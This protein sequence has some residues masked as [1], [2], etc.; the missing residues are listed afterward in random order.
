MIGRTAGYQIGGRIGGERQ[1]G[2]QRTRQD[3][4][5]FTR[6][7]QTAGS[8]D[9]LVAR[10]GGGGD[11]GRF[12]DHQPL[13]GGVV[14]GRLRRGRLRVAQGIAGV[15]QRRCHLR[16]AGLQ[17]IDAVAE[18]EIGRLDQDGVV[19]HLRHVAQ[20]GARRFDDGSVVRGLVID[21]WSARC[22]SGRRQ[23]LRNQ[24]QV[25]LHQLPAP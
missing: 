1:G 7:E 12:L 20:Q 23:R 4:L 22:R 11:A 16:G 13:R 10:G 17:R 24:V 8:D 9:R 14:A 21:P 18:P 2:W 5:E 15:A 25:V 6:E 3:G 19:L